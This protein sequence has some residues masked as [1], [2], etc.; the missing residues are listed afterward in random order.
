MVK[1]EL[2]CSEED[3]AELWEE[4]VSEFSEEDSAELSEEDVSEDS[5]E[6]TLDSEDLLLCVLE[7]CSL[8]EDALVFWLSDEEAEVASVVSTVSWLEEL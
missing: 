6:I 1:S 3:E 8:L 4:E 7:E 2:G 5:E